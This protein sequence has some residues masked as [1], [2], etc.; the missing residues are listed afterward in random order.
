M[1]RRDNARVERRQ[2]AEGVRL[3][4]EAG[5]VVKFL[6]LRVGAPGDGRAMYRQIVDA[7][8]CAAASGRIAERSPLPTLLGTAT[9]LGVNLNTVGRAYRELHQA[10]VC[11]GGQRQHG[12]HLCAGGQATARGILLVRIANLRAEADRLRAAAGL[13]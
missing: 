10:G 6:G 3:R 13:S 8:L 2:A 11:D 1:I 9:L 7:V 4:R 5:E 12:V